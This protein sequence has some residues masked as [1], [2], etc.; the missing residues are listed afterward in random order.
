MYYLRPR[1]PPHTRTRCTRRAPHA[2]R[3]RPVGG[4]ILRSVVRSGGVLCERARRRTARHGGPDAPQ[5]LPDCVCVCVRVCVC[6]CVCVR[7]MASWA[8]AAGASTARTSRTVHGGVLY[9]ARASAGHVPCMHRSRAAHAQVTCRAC[10]GHVPR[11]HRSRAARVALGAVL[12]ARQ[13]LHTHS[14][15]VLHARHAPRTAYDAVY[16]VIVYGYTYILIYSIIY[17]YTMYKYI[18]YIFI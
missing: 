15:A 10:T 18:L 11:M 3:V 2:R 17:I 16:G 8:G 1:L 14:L 5:R 9:G 13:L 4:G 6:A 7:G 12:H